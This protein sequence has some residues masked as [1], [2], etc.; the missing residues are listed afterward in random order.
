M[1]ETNLKKKNIVSAK[2]EDMKK[3]QMKI[4]ELKVIISKIK[5]LNVS[6]TVGDEGDRG[7]QQ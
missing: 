4:L 7:K 2:I 3:Y 5:S 1:L 6:S